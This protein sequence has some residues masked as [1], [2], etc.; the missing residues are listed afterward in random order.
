MELTLPEAAAL[1]DRYR[2]EGRL[3]MAAKLYREILTKVPDNASVHTNL[4]RVLLLLGEFA[5]GWPEYEWR[6]AM[7][8]AERPDYPVPRW[9]GGG[10]DGRTLFLHGEQGYGD[11]IQFSRYVPLAA[12]HG[13]RVVVG[14]Q[15]GFR[16][17]LS[18]MDGMCDIV[19]SGEGIPPFQCH[20]PMASLPGA[21]ATSLLNIPDRVPYL[22]AE[23][24]RVH[25][26]KRRV[27]V[28][29][30]LAVGICWQANPRFA[31]DQYRSVPLRL[32]EPLLCTPR[33]DF[34][35]LQILHGRDQMAELPRGTAFQDLGEELYSETE[36]LVEAAAAMMALDLVIT[37]DTVIAHLAGALGRPVWVLLSHV[38]D[39]RWLLDREDSPWYPTMR[40]FRQPRPGD[41]ASVFRAVGDALAETRHANGGN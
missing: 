26:W 16:R 9:D 1:A 19:E 18:A 6:W 33:V 25:A 12:A 24:A 17:L 14:C 22:R 29:G 31:E 20:L 28:D 21:F 10:L 8:A 34:Y 15:S 30:R 32:F 36:V 7:M 2:L 37:V 3:V 39:W 23:A 4:G 38:P 5:A 35:G 40:L 13:G 27:V 41:W 11:V